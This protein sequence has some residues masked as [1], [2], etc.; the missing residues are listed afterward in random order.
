MENSMQNERGQT[1]VIVAFLVIVLLVFVGLAVDGGTAI[2]GRRRMQNSADAG[3]LAGA[4]RLA[5][6]VCS[7]ES[8]TDADAAIWAEIVSYARRN[9]VEETSRIFA[10]YVKY[11]GDSVVEYDPPVLVGGGVVPNGAVGVAVNVG[12]EH[13]TYFVKL[14]G[15]DNSG[16]Q[17]AATAVTGPP[18]AV[19]GGLKPFGVPQK[20]F[21]D[22]AIGDCFTIGFGNQCDGDDPQANNCYITTDGGQVLHPHRGW[23]NLDYAWNCTEA[24][25]FPRALNAN[26]GSRTLKDWMSDREPWV[27][28]LN[29]DCDWEL[30]CGCGDFIHAKPGTNQSVIGE[31]PIGQDFVIPIFDHIAHESEILSAKPDDLPHQGGGYF[32]HIVGFATVNVPYQ[33]DPSEHSI[34]ACLQSAVWGEGQPSPN[35]GFGS[36]ACATGTLVVTLWE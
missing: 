32:Y 12:I 21:A 11:D 17:A 20:I 28:T 31:V 29:A 27:G 25:A 13:D 35:Q 6:A 5:S 18:R 14:I 26:V 19:G 7:S 1:I 2:V 33:T 34:R 36:D 9:G 4:H 23:L 24:P 16:A 10:R 22:L 8:A 3:A 30:G 15:I